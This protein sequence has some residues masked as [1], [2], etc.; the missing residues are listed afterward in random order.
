M[1]RRKTTKRGERTREIPSGEPL[2]A[3]EKILQIGLGAKGRLCS[4]DRRTGAKTGGKGIPK[5][6]LLKVKKRGNHWF[7][8][9]LTYQE[10]NRDEGKV[11]TGEEGKIKVRE[12][13]LYFRGSEMGAGGKSVE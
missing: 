3:A 7:G 6:V 11:E 10:L 4:L 8:E 9:K 13:L 2:C 1:A 5:C 12:K